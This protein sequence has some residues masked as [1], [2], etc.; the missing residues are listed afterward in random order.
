MCEEAALLTAT[1]RGDI[2]RYA[3][4]WLSRFAGFLR[5]LTAGGADDALLREELESHLEM[6]TADNVRRGM[7]PAEARHQALVSAG[8]LTLAREAVRERRSLP[9]A[10]TLVSDTR[11][12]MRSLR[13]SPAFTAVAVITLALGVGANTAIFSV[14]NGIVLRPLAYRDADRLLSLAS[15]VNRSAAAVSPRDFT[16]W[17]SQA[18][19]FSGLAAAYTSSTV[20]TGAGEPEQLSQAR[21]SANAF[22]L[23]GVR[24]L[25][26]RAFVDGE[27]Q[28]SAPRVAM[29]SEGSWRRRFGGDPAIVGRTLLFD[30]F[31]TVVIGIA[32]TDMRWPEPADVWMA[33]RFSD[34]DLAE[35]ARGARWI[36]VIGRLAPTATVD[37]ARAEMDAVAL[38]LAR[39]DPRHNA[40]VGTRVT[41]L[42]ASMV[43]DI[44]Q[45]LFLLLGA[46][47]F[48]LLIACANV[49]SLTLGRVV[50]RDAELAV[51]GALGAGRGR[52]AGQLLTESLLVSVAGGICGLLLAIAG[53]KAL[54]AIAPSD[55]PR[56]HEVALDGRVLAFTSG[57]TLL[58]AVL[59]GVVP[60]L[61]GGSANLHDRLRTAGRGTNAAGH[62]ARSRRSLVVVEVALATVLLAGAGLL[63]R[64]FA[65][66]RAVD[67]GFRPDGVSMFGVALS[68]AKYA[69]DD[70]QRQFTTELLDKIRHAPG[71]TSAGV[72][73]DLP[74]SD[75]SFGFT[76]EVLG[77]A[78]ADPKDEPRAQ[79]RVATPEYFSAMGIPLV[80]GRLFDESY[81]AGSRQVLII[82]NEVA[83][84]Y[85]PNENPIGKYVRTGWGMGGKKFGGEVIG[86]VGDV[87]QFALDRGMTPHLYMA[88]QQWPLNEYDVV[89]RSS[90]PFAA[91]ID[92]ARLALRQLDPEIPMNDAKP[93]SR[94]VD[95]SLGPRRFY[96][97][98]LTAFASIAMALALVGI[99]GVVA[100][101]VQQR[102]REIGVRLALG[103][104]RQR[105]LRMVLSE[106]L[107]LAATGVAIGIV[108][109]FWL[110]RLLETLLFNVGAHDVVAFALAPAALIG[111]AVLACV[112]P[113][114]S[115]ASVNPVETIRAD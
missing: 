74:L 96:L 6:H 89:I 43:G 29:L 37:G 102:R 82:S 107:A 4:A 2:M 110:T 3:R 18:R 47:G 1:P 28:A 38:R 111:A 48:V 83:R 20:L 71:V 45:P 11:Y 31:P 105:V 19:S 58:T 51:R 62:R 87:R 41:P 86:V 30:G 95:A 27:D 57:L 59:F 10:E 91:V 42:L 113:A 8:G 75:E 76:F 33:T 21:V 12:A 73:F 9:W 40:N 60:A 70:Q 115:A 63:L 106:G 36:T 61:H 92:A 94:L 81:H 66:M 65:Q 15:I 24:P 64:S 77:R 17:R 32:P 103:A 79:A 13:R 55:L 93:L 97:T 16:D 99:Y 39:L 7:S 72:S 68:P 67:P 53:T 90:A 85:F 25:L 5:S 114:R 23:L 54:V 98:L 52:I 50:A 84:R 100:Y 108:A 44:R 112:L 69:G 109:S 88:Y 22:A 56:I 104:S 101:G 14:V 49:A 78:P 34:R 46:V 80:R 35:S 26:G